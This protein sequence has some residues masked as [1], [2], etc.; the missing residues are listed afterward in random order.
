MTAYADL[1]NI[2]ATLKLTGSDFANDDLESAIASASSGLDFELGRRFDLGDPDTPRLFTP[3]DAITLPIND[4]ADLTSVLVDQ[5]GD[6]VF[7]QTWVRDTDFVLLPLNAE[8]DGE[9][10]THLEVRPSGRYSLPVGG[11]GAVKITGQWGWLNTPDRIVE[12]TGLIATQLLQRK[13]TAPFGVQMMT[14]GESVVAAY[15][16]KH[17]PHIAWLTRGLSRRAPITSPSLG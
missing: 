12:A 5:D 17:D 14:A 6:G 9:P 4:L 11:R 7:E 16:A 8:A 13:R 15:I 3:Q 1:D 10:W 2:K